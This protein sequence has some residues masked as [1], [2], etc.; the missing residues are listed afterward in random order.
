MFNFS[1]FKA[2]AGYYFCAIRVRIQALKLDN[3]YKHDI[4]ALS[5]IHTFLE[6]TLKTVLKLL[7]FVFFLIGGWLIWK[8]FYV[9]NGDAKAIVFLSGCISLGIAWMIFTQVLIA[10]K[11]PT[12]RKTCPKGK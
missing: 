4:L 8:M 11:E 9:Q 3:I 7:S 5:H 2:S 6:N 1:L 10:P 12:S